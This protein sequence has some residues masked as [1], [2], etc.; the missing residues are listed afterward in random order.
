MNSGHRELV[1]NLQ[2]GGQSG[3]PR[4]ING[5][6]RLPPVSEPIRNFTP[7]TSNLSALPYSPAHTF[8][9]RLDPYRPSQFETTFQTYIKYL[10]SISNLLSDGA[11]SSV[12][13]A[14]AEKLY[15]DNHRL[16][17]ILVID[18][19]LIPSSTIIDS[20]LP[21]PGRAP[22]DIPPFARFLS[23]SHFTKKTC[24]RVFFILNKKP[25]AVHLFYHLKVTFEFDYSAE[26][27]RRQDAPQNPDIF[28][29]SIIPP[30]VKL[31]TTMKENGR[32]YVKKLEFNPG[33]SVNRHDPL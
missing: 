30:K 1:F 18:A 28:R 22:D 24:R 14:L 2:A 5:E 21:L 12:A 8:N 19:A 25:Y 4:L 11:I 16:L 17:S 10:N 27:F 3:R 15:L 7:S 31:Y 9:L 20:P 6:I 23:Y 13:S 32:N 29:Y 33:P 26:K